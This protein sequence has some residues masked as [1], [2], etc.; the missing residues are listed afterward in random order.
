MVATSRNVAVYVLVV[1]VIVAASYGAIAKT[2]CSGI[3]SLAPIPEGGAIAFV[4]AAAGDVDGLQ[5]FNNDENVVFPHVSVVEGESESGYAPGRV[6]AVV[7]DVSGPSQEWGTLEFGESIQ[8]STGL[9]YVVFELPPDAVYERVG[10]GGGPGIGYF[11]DEAGRGAYLLSGGGADGRFLGTGAVA[12]IGG[13]GAEKSM[14]GKSGGTMG[15]DVGLKGPRLWTWP[16]PVTSSVELSFVL[17]R[18]GPYNL[19]VYDMRGRL[20]R[21]VAS[22]GGSAGEC[23]RIWDG[24]DNAGRRLGAGVYYAR[25]LA[26][27]AIRAQRMTILR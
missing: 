24:T 9:Y 1:T 17:N 2:T 19:A 15:M 16:N 25:L 14:P 18:D 10:V 7:G 21:H 6:L 23:T 3:L 4:V 13:G 22:G 5:W 12:L 20:V 11:I 27:G 8:S 26:E